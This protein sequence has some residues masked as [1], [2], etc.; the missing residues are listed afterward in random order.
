MAFVVLVT[1]RAYNAIKTRI[2]SGYDVQPMENT[3]T[4]ADIVITATQDTL[5]AI[6]TSVVAG[7]LPWYV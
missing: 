7:S 3:E 1:V 6:G 2:R 4:T 5:W